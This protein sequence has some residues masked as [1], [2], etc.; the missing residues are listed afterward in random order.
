MAF[1]KFSNME[2][3][4]FTRFIRLNVPSVQLDAQGRARP[5]ISALYQWRYNKLGNLPHTSTLPEYVRANP[6]F[7]FEYQLVDV[8]DFNGAGEITPSIHF[9]QNL[10]EAEYVV[11]TYMYMRLLG[12]PAD[13]VTVLTTY[14]GQKELLRDILTAKC[15][16]HPLFGMPAAVWHRDIIEG[17]SQ[18]PRSRL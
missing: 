11:A 5:S 8:G 7:R 1:K 9:F 3:S 17:H 14:N 18:P 2:Q 10:A 4:L 12:Y 16:S 6:G 13:R 15:G